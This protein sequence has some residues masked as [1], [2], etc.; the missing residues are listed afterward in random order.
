MSALDAPALRSPSPSTCEPWTGRGQNV[1]RLP[2]SYA[3]RRHNALLER[4][5]VP[6][7]QKPPRLDVQLSG[8]VYRRGSLFVSSSVPRRK[9]SIQ[10]D[11]DSRSWRP[12]VINDQND[13]FL[14]FTSMEVSDRRVT[15]ASSH[16][17]VFCSVAYVGINRLCTSTNKCVLGE[18]GIVAI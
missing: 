8:A 5:T 12:N 18:T 2:C 13:A 16:Q 1:I 15:R 7:N 3:R 17:S 14:N 6:G 11:I 10:V 9:A 4:S